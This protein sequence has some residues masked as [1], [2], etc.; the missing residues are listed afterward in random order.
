MIILIHFDIMIQREKTY[1]P[2]IVKNNI[3]CIKYYIMSE[4]SS[5]RFVKELQGFYEKL[6]MT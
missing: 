2:I 3:M 6:I 4:F 5:L 1:I